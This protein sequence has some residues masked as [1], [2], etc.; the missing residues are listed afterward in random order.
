MFVNDHGSIGIA[1]E[2]R[3]IRSE[4]FTGLFRRWWIRL[5]NLW[6]TRMHPMPMW[7]VRGSYRCP[8]C[9]REH[10]VPWEARASD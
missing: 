5:G 3:E 4:M 1:E 6:C 2:P 7:P 10:P 9:L 8:A